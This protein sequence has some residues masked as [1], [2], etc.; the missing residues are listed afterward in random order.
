MGDD[1]TSDVELLTGDAAAFGRFYRRHES[2]VLGFFKRRVADP[3]VVADLTAETFARLLEGRQRFDPA[4]GEPT[5][6]LFG[7]ARHVLFRSLAVGRVDDETRRRLAMEPLALDDADLDAI[8]AL[9][10]APALSALAHLPIEQQQAVTGRVIDDK[11]YA[12]LAAELTCSQSVV[13][14]RVSRGLRTLRLA[15]KERP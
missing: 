8:N 2:A 14:Q 4:L 7:I 5:A 6:W 1:L 9:T 10:D 12:E 15:L 13:R 11:P 3:E